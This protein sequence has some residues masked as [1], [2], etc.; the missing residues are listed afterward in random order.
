MLKILLTK[1][2]R[3]SSV[4]NYQNFGYNMRM[5]SCRFY[6]WTFSISKTLDSEQKS[7]TTSQ[8]KR[9]QN[10]EF[11]KLKGDI[12]ANKAS[13]PINSIKNLEF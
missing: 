6:K 5:L 1:H 12:I 8:V 13:E 2:E 9:L 4:L 3:R 11:K 7:D 10:D